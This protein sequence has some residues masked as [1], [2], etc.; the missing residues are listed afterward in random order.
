MYCRPLA[1]G[2]YNVG[3]TFNRKYDVKSTPVGNVRNGRGGGGGGTP[4]QAGGPPNANEMDR[5]R[6]S[7]LG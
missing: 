7:I 1:D 3:A 2:I 5:I 4:V 6:Q